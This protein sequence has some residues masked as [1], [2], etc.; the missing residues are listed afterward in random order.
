MNSESRSDARKPK[1][2]SR[3]TKSQL[4]KST[5]HLHLQKNNF[6]RTCIRILLKDS[7][8]KLVSNGGFM[9]L[10]VK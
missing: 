7:E 6:F 10:Q 8:E 1:S 4:L 3:I 9:D 2:P 5:K